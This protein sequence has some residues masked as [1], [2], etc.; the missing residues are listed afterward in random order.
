MISCKPLSLAHDLIDFFTLVTD[1]NLK[2]VGSCRRIIRGVVN[3]ENISFGD[4]QLSGFVGT[5]FNGK[6]CAGCG[7]KNVGQLLADHKGIFVYCEGD[8]DRARLLALVHHVCSVFDHGTCKVAKP[9]NLHCQKRNR[10]R[11]DDG[12][13]V[14][15]AAQCLD[16]EN[17][18]GHGDA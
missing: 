17:A 13:N 11:C 9:R 15:E 18:G 4:A 14:L 1:E 3:G 16:G 10:N 8:L 5:S 7:P 6:K 2:F 12:K